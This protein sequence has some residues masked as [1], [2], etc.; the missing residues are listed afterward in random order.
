LRPAW[1]N[2]NKTISEAPMS[3]NK[4]GVVVCACN[5]SYAGGIDRR[6]KWSR[7]SRAKT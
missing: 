6:I 7:L 1:A 3:I 5:P 4:P 2:N